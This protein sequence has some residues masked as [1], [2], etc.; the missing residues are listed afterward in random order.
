MSTIIQ[1]T[2]QLLTLLLLEIPHIIQ[3]DN[4]GGGRGD[5]R[6]EFERPFLVRDLEIGG[7]KLPITPVTIIILTV[8]GIIL[9][10]T[11]TKQSTAVASHILLD[12]TTD[13]VKEK[14]LK[15]KAEINNDPQK[16]AKFAAK[17]S[18][19]P[20]GKSGS[21][22]GS[23]GKFPL[24]VMAP[25]FDR[26]VFSRNSKVGEVLGPVPT[27]FGYHLILIHERDEQRQLVTY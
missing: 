7:V 21:P 24:G 15:M 19:C 13:E 2:L 3:A 16:F 22:P 6:T 20:S 25:T 1:K 10:R 26:A 18:T 11:F 27:Q 8:S 12:G 5:Y 9:Y 17:Y 4:N 23:L 14:M